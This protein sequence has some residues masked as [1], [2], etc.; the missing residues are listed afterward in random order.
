[1]MYWNGHGMNGW[2]IALMS[3]S[4]LLVLGLLTAGVVL[5]ARYLGRA[6]VEPP[7][8][9]PAEPPAALHTEPR[10]PEALLAERLA[11][12][13]IDADEYRQRLEALRSAHR[14][15]SG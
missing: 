8:R 10:A 15:A 7:A 1:M 12:G 11:R 5:L 4:T 9:P 13:Q 14:P 2:G 6:T 3:L